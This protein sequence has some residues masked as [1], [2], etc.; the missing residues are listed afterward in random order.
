MVTGLYTRSPA[1]LPSPLYV[2]VIIGHSLRVLGDAE[3]CRLRD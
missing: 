3:G 1:G 2:T